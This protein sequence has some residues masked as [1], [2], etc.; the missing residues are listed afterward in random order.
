ML[1]KSANVIRFKNKSPR[2]NRL[3]P[4]EAYQMYEN[5][6]SP[7]YVVLQNE[8]HFLFYCA[9]TFTSNIVETMV[10]DIQVKWKTVM[11]VPL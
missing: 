6:M 10:I 3:W 4:S 9:Y 11:L 5:A 8:S 7:R 2:P 1:Y